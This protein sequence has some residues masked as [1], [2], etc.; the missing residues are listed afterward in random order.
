[1]NQRFQSFQTQ[2]SHQASISFSNKIGENIN[3][4]FTD[5]KAPENLDDED[6]KD[7]FA[8]PMRTKKNLAYKSIELK[9]N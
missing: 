8:N 1:M 3:N 9:S 4:I 5:D 6:N 7:N 2:R